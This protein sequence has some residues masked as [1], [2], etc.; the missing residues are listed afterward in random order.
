MSDALLA[1]Y[2]AVLFDLDGTVYHGS[3]V[4]PGAPETLKAVRGQGTPVRFVTNNASK[5]PEA[6]VAH[7]VELGMPAGPD[8]VHTSAQAAVALLSELLDKGAAV[9]VVGTRSLAEGVAAAGLK[10]VRKNAETVQA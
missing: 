9:L 10:P 2:D 3:Q 8:E 7:L 6:V 1:A 5:A 4:I